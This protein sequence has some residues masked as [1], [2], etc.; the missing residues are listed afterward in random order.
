MQQTPA[1]SLFYIAL[2]PPCL[3]RA[4][5]ARLQAPIPLSNLHFSRANWRQ[6]PMSTFWPAVA[7]CAK[8]DSVGAATRI[9]IVANA[10]K[11]TNVRMISPLTNAVPAS[12]ATPRNSS[13]RSRGPA[14]VKAGI[15]AV[16]PAQFRQPLRKGG[17]LGPPLWVAL[18]RTQEHADAP[19]PVALLRAHR[20]R[21]RDRCAAE[22]G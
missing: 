6:V 5:A 19:H 17:E 8:A 21:P 3:Q 9:I 2:G 13:A 7:F 15:A 10:L 4:T 18:A 16:G 22:R 11:K 12:R 20:E 14:D 1:A